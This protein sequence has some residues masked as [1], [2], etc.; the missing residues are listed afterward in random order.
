[1][2]GSLRGV[3]DELVSDQWDPTRHTP[4]G[5]DVEA[6]LTTR[7]EILDGEI[8]HV[9]VTPIDPLASPKLAA[10]VARIVCLRVAAVVY[11]R[12]NPA[13]GQE[14][15]GTRQSRVMREEADG[16]RDGILKGAVAD[17]RLKGG[18]T[19]DAMGAPVG[20]FPAGGQAFRRDQ[21]F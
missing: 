13:G 10:V 6:M 15:M 1:M 16:L 8:D 4:S 12:L 9:V 2:Y 19:P 20:H 21:R 11:D 17:G 3:Q 7:S 5:A 18:R 14:I